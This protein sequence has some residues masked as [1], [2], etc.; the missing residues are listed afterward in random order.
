VSHHDDRGDI[1]KATSWS[2]FIGQTAM[3]ERL[4][5]HIKAAVTQQRMLDHVLLAGP[6]GFGKTSLAYII[7]AELSDPYTEITM[8]MRPVA[9]AASLHRFPGGVLFLD[10]IHRASKGEQENLLKLL[11]QGEYSLPNGRCVQVEN[12]TV[13]AATTEPE[14]VIPPLYDRFVYKPAFVDYSDDDMG[15]IVLSMAA[16]AGVD[17]DVDVALELG[18]AAGGTPR[19]GR[20]LVFAAR[21]IA[22]TGEK[23]TTAA[24]LSLCGMEPDGLSAQHLEYL[25]QLGNLNGQAGLA[26]LASIMR[27]HPTTVTNLERLLLKRGL[28]AYDTGGRI[29][30]A[31]GYTRIKK[32]T[33]L[34]R[35]V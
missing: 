26:V 16:K 21:D 20:Q 15:T 9:F 1:L 31:S 18:H 11:D 24:I 19:N 7:A 35:V 28:I 2:D 25:N 14:K 12:M 13:I 27:L 8:P 3:K 22:S 17:L 4:S 32:T 10:E 6:P 5:L 34:R 23:I 33:S 30:T 29:L